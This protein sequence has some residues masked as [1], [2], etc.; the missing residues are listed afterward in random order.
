MGVIS[1][2]VYANTALQSVKVTVNHKNAPISKVLDDIEQ[3]TGYS[4]LVRNND[5]NIKQKV[6]VNVTG[7]LNT[8]LADVFEGMEVKYNVEN[9]TISIYKEKTP[10]F[11]ASSVNQ[12]KKTVTGTIVDQN[13][14][15]IIGAN[16]SIP[17]TTTGTIS[18]VDGRFSIEVPENAQLQISFIGY[19]SQVISVENKT[20][21]NVK[22]QEDT[23]KLDEVV[24]V[25]YMTQKKGI[26]DRICRTYAS[27]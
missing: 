26:V 27:R 6:T 4:I 20:V 18:D 15:P 11:V 22:L 24:V 7:S 9:K 2:S 17:G 23:Q 25:G 21:I 16:V 10:S 3:Q 5:I 1:T 8:V 13:G 14:E 12:D 19:L